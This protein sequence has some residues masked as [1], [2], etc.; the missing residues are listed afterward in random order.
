LPLGGYVALPQL[1]DMAA[2][3]GQ[4]SSDTKKLPPL[5]WSDK[6]IVSVMGAVFNVL[7]ACVL[8]ILLW[9]VGVPSSETAQTTRVGFVLPEFTFQ[10]GETVPSP[11]A[12]AGILPGDTILEID[13][14]PVDEWVDIPQRLAT[15][16]RRDSEGNR[17]AT[18]SIDRNG[19]ILQISVYPVLNGEE[20]LRQVGIAPYHKVIVGALIRNSPAHEAGVRRGDVLTQMDGQEV[21]S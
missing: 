4:A 9:L 11:A 17:M 20:Q 14:S 12:Q 13:G 15:G 21:M 2:I 3:E 1:A 18:F 19:E 5:S 7:F 10:N 16:S 6:M 8:A